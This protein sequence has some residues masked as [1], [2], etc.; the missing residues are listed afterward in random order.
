MDFSRPNFNQ[1][2]VIRNGRVIDPTQVLDQVADIYIADGLISNIGNAPVGFKPDMEFDAEGMLVIPGAVDVCARVREPGQTQK[3]NIH[4]ETHA[5][6][7]AGVTHLCCPPDTNPVIDTRA[8]AALIQERAYQSGY[9]HVMPIGALTKGLDGQQL[10]EM[11]SLREAGCIG[12]SQLRHPVKDA[13]VLLRCLEY[14][15]TFD[16]IVFFQS[17]EQ[18]ISPAGG[19]HAGPTATRLGLPGIPECAE[20][21]ALSR[22]LLL[23]EQTGVRAHFGQISCARS[24]ELIATA[25]AKGLPVTADV[26][27]HQLYLTDDMIDGFNSQ[28][29]VRPPART[30]ADRQALID[31]VKAG[32]ISVLCS[33]H[34]PH[35]AAAKA[36]PFPTTAAGIS[37]FSHFLPLSY[38]FVRTGVLTESEWVQRIAMNPALL[39]G[40]DAGHLSM[41]SNANLCVFDPNESWKLSRDNMVSQGKNSPFIGRTL[42]GRVKLTLKDG[43]LSYRHS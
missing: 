31:G 33:D 35:E 18:S 20:T 15:S 17:E 12:V 26:A 42:H 39:I 9:A 21:I 22:D 32:V 8:V 14:A 41:G 24:V 13:Q 40:L 38:E 43:A 19:V 29:H 16:L 28:Y 11:H 4:S 27:V 6:A 1:R 10:S 2:I 23:V 5:A 34:Q 36:E 30:E 37:A 7:A 25:Q 3:G